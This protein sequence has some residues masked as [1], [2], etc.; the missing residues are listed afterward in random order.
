M[1]EI[2]LIDDD[3]DLRPFLQ[4]ALEERGYRVHCLDRAD[5]ALDTLANGEFDLVVVDEMMPGL[6]G[7]ELIKVLRRQENDIPVI[8]M[9]GLGT[10][11]LIE[12]MKQLGAL[13]VPKPAAG[14]GELLK[15]LVAAVEETLQG[16][17]EIV[18]LISRMVKRALQ[19]GKTAPHLRWLLDCELRVQVSAVNHDPER[20]RQILGESEGEEHAENAIRLKAEVWHLRFH[21]ESGDYPRKGNQSLVWIHK[22]LAA[23]NKPFTVAE[24]QGDPL[25]KLAADGALGDE[26]QTDDAGIKK[27][28][29]RIEE[30]DDIAKETGGSEALDE[31]KA[32]LEKQ[33][34]ESLRGKKMDSSLRDAHRNI[35]VQIRALRDKKLAKGMPRLAAHL[36]AALKLDFPYI[37]YYPPPG[38]SAWQ[39]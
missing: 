33:F 18:E 28:K 16:G 7:S 38:T 13:V 12:P 36:R 8:L 31:E 4:S 29:H 39:I 27:I 25:G 19:L 21:G 14:S 17:A 35:A 3:E 32:V 22:L 10:R 11:S 15:D 2:L 5:G 9:T 24:L 34:Q 26:G 37:G 1:A 30:I 23:P 6:H 20:I